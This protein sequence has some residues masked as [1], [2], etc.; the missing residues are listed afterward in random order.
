MKGLKIMLCFVIVGLLLDFGC[1]TYQIGYPYTICCSVVGAIA[2]IFIKRRNDTAINVAVSYL[3][4][5]YR[6]I[7][8]W[9]FNYPEVGLYVMN[10]REKGFRVAIL[11]N[12]DDAS[13][14]ESVLFVEAKNEWHVSPDGQWLQRCCNMSYLGDGD[15]FKKD[16]FARIREKHPE[17]E[18]DGFGNIVA[19][20]KF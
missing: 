15:S 13:L 4:D 18:I 9:P 6:M 11:L 2:T 19:N 7:N 1:R 12:R 16:V 8:S 10:P 14:L 3:E 5:G 20:R 17:W